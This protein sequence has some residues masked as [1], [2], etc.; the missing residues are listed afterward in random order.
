MEQPLLKVK[1]LKKHVPIKNKLFQKQNSS[2]KA[3]DGISFDVNRGETI[4]LVGERGCGKSTTGRMLM[5][6]LDPTEGEIYY[7]GEDVTNLEERDLCRYRKKI[8]MILQDPD[9]SLNRRI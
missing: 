6:W 4:G 1:N 3:V 5:K 8:H 9:A 7:N 2:V